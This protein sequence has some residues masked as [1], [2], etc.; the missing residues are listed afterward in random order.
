M[1]PWGWFG[2]GFLVGWFMGYTAGRL[3]GKFFWKGKR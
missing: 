1:D 2:I 3:D